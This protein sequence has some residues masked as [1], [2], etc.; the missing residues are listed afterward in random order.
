MYKKDLE[1]T[2]RQLMVGDSFEEGKKPSFDDE[3]NERLA[4]IGGD[5]SKIVHNQDDETYVVANAPMG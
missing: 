2:K 1:V 4:T 3:N 5:L